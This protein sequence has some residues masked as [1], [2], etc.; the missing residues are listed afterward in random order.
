MNWAWLLLIIS[1]QVMFAAPHME[2]ESRFEQ[3]GKFI[4]GF[5]SWL[6]STQYIYIHLDEVF[7]KIWITP[8]LWA[9]GCGPITQPFFKLVANIKAVFFYTYDY[10]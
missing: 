2:M 9:T 4:C 7:I 8:M 1:T 6:V 5:I 3:M 10:F